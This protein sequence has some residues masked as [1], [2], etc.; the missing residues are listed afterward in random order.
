MAGTSRLCREVHTLLERGEHGKVQRGE[1]LVCL[2]KGPHPDDDLTRSLHFYP[3]ID[4]GLD[5]DRLELPAIGP[6]WQQ[7]RDT[8]GSQR[9]SPSADPRDSAWLN[10]P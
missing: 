7:I 2:I 1:D 4:T 5:E 3:G 6:E 10:R 9:N 8:Y